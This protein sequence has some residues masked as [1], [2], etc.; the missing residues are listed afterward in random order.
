MSG[1]KRDAIWSELNQ[2]SQERVK[3]IHCNYE[4]SAQAYRMKKQFDEKHTNIT[5]KTSRQCGTLQSTNMENL[6]LARPL[7]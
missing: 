2:I 7:T 4:S 3:C 6:S 1:R 5:I